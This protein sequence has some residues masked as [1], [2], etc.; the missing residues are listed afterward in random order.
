MTT[1]R[2][3][4]ILAADV[5]GFSSMMEKDEEGTLRRVKAL[6]RELI[7]PKVRERGGRLVKTTG[8]GFLCEF[9][10]PVEAVRCALEVQEA[11]AANG[12]SDLLLRMGINLGDIIVEPDGD[13]YGEGVNVAA[14]LEQLAEP[15][16]LCIAGSVQEHA[17]GKVGVQFESRGEQQVKNIARP[18]RVY[19]FAGTAQKVSEPK[20]LPLPDKPSIAVL[21]FTNMSGDPEQEYF[22]DGVV[23]DIITALS[24]VRWLFVIARNSSFTYKGHAVDVKQVGRE[25]GVRY[26]LEGSI[27]KAGN[28]LRITGQ[29]VEA[30]TGT[31]LWADRFDGALEDVFDVQDRVTENVVGAIEPKLRQAELD[32]TRR[33]PTTSLSAYDLY[34][35]AAFLFDQQDDA[36]EAL[37][38]LEQAIGLDPNFALAYA[39]AAHFHARRIYDNQTTDREQEAAKGRQR[40]ATAL[41]K[42]SDD[43]E[44]FWRCAHA[45]SHC[46]A[47]LTYCQSLGER[48][49]ALNPNSAPALSQTAWV[50]IYTGRYERA[51]ELFERAM[52]LSPRDAFL[53][54]FTSGLC[55]ALI[56]LERPHEA[57]RWGRETLALR[58]TYPTGM[59]MLASSLALSGRVDE[60][61]NIIADLLR[62]SPQ[63]CISNLTAAITSTPNAKVYVEGLRRAGYPE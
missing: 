8:D 47:D 20:P 59:R 22:A 58:P 16:G 39:L 24:R 17:E 37:Q 43:P 11:T 32:R 30:E 45:L 42:S 26:V 62:V 52:R 35:R 31:H 5:V 28:R 54:S 18:V 12:G 4:A 14:R 15:G 25:L 6:Q 53:Y 3:A 9:S 55:A 63:A 33:K 27:R 44:I 57:V 36:S 23:E 13:I 1:R 41:E 60:A 40:A 48:A 61:R 21:P 10:S 50:H 46:G 29:L 19:A 56:F 49:I 34:L 51:I 2:L 38:L 7:E